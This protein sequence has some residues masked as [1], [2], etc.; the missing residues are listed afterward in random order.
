MKIQNRKRLIVFS[1]L[2]VVGYLYFCIVGGINNGMRVSDNRIL[3]TMV[4]FSNMPV[5]VRNLSTNIFIWVIL[6][7]FLVLLILWQTTLSGTKLNRIALICQGFNLL[8]ICLSRGIVEWIVSGV[9]EGLFTM[10]IIIVILFVIVSVS[11]GIT[12]FVQKRNGTLNSYEA[13][14]DIMSEDEFERWKRN[15]KTK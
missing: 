7:F 15:N 1:I 10:L 11:V 3:D 14:S 12:Y 5:S 9:A 8:F 6:S 13:F 4:L 2:Y